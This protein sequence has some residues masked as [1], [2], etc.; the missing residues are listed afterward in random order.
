MEKSKKKKKLVKELG[1]RYKSLNVVQLYDFPDHRNSKGW[2]AE[3][4]AIL[5]NLDERDY[6]EFIGLRKSLYPGVERRIRINTANEIDGFIRQKVAEY[7]R[8]DFS[9]LD[10]PTLSFPKIKL[11]E[12]TKR[13]IEKIIVAILIA[14]ILAWLGLR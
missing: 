8:D 9:Y 12:W 2:L 4:A 10:T 1:Q 7:K 13:N 3:V 11:P 14:A 5:K 6:Q